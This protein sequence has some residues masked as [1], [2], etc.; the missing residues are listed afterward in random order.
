MGEG[1]DPMEVE[2]GWMSFYVMTAF[3]CYIAFSWFLNRWPHVLHQRK[4]PPSKSGAPSGGPHAASCTLGAEGRRRGEHWG[5]PLEGP[6]PLSIAHRGGQAEAPENTVHAFRYALE[7]CGCDM[8]ELDVWVS[9]DGHLVVT[10]DDELQRVCGVDKK[11]SET[12]LKDLPLILSSD[13]IEKKGA[14][15]EFFPDFKGFP[16]PFGSQKIPTLEEVYAAFPGVLMN[17]DLKGPYD[18]AAVS[19]AVSLTRKYK[20]E[21]L[22]I[23]GGFMQKKLNAIKKEMPE[24]LVATGP[25]RSLLL[26][27]AYYV[28]LLPFCPIWE[29]AFEFP[30]SYA[31]IQREALRV[32]EQRRQLLPQCCRFLYADTR[33]RFKAWLSYTLLT[34][35]GFLEALKR[36]GLLVLGWVA[37]TVDEYEE[38]LFRMGCHGIMTDRPKHFRDYLESRIH[39]DGNEGAPKGAPS[40][41]SRREAK[42][43]C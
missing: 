9:K 42:K 22:T 29:D 43:T 37:N 33:A 8:I 14:F 18:P 31:Y 40:K 35:R 28:G 16:R 5:G 26:L 32:A 39:A 38:A 21:R 34:N 1:S 41:G 12:N 24:A 3:C 7:E 25:L 13:E 4:G 27:V 23:F 30:V 20:R 6:P 19:Q 11:V 10:H 15:F 17:V 2:S 36:R